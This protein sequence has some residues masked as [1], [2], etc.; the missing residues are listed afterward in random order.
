MCYGNINIIDAENVEMDHLKL[1][2]NFVSIL[3]VI[4]VTTITVVISDG[5]ICLEF[6]S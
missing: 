3:D 6:P 4:Y 5:K 2:L 1:Y